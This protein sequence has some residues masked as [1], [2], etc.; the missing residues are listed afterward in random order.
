VSCT[1][2]KREN[3]QEQDQAKSAKVVDKISEEHLLR[4][5]FDENYQGPYDLENAAKTVPDYP[6]WE[7]VYFQQG[8][9]VAKLEKLVSR[10]WSVG[11]W[12]WQVRVKF[13]MDNTLA[14]YS[15]M[16]FTVRYPLIEFRRPLV[17]TVNG[18]ANGQTHYAYQGEYLYPRFSYLKGMILMLLSSLLSLLALGLILFG[19][20]KLWMLIALKLSEVMTPGY[21]P[22]NLWTIRFVHWVMA[23]AVMFVTSIVLFFV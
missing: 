3:K 19:L 13:D 17:F 21:G 7:D 4:Q 16:R 14:R 15:E 20:Y 11:P 22:P 6:T 12:W 8:D 9:Y 2:E 1:E 23:A 10:D 18:D 5:L